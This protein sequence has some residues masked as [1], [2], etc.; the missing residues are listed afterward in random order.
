M[1][2]LRISLSLILLA[3]YGS[4]LTF[5]TA[6]DAADAFLGGAFFGLVLLMLVGRFTRAVVA[7]MAALLAIMYFHFGSSAQRVGWDHHHT[8]LLMVSV[9]IL[10]LTPCGRS[11]SLDRFFE[12][13]RAQGAGRKP[14]PERG[15]LWAVKLFGL[16]LS[17][18][19]FWAA[20]DKTNAAFLSGERLEQIIIWH[21]AGRP[22]APIVLSTLFLSAAPVAVVAVEYFLAAAIHIKR[23][24]PCALVLGCG[25]HAAFYL[26]LPVETFSITMIA[27]YL[28]VAD[29]AKVDR[30]VKTVTCGAVAGQQ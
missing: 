10:A 21:H 7:T 22:L 2:L 20:V 1:G 29:P 9:A 3:R 8:Y 14:P 25:L 19:Y 15:S 5:F 18:V 17:A 16:Q 26:L 13:R 27:L 30:A 24:L 28:A 23:L 12:V 6:E 11:F 4:E